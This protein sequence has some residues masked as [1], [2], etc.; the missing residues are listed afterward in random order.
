MRILVWDDFPITNSGGPSGYVYNVYEYLKHNPSENIFFLS[1]LRKTNSHQTN[2]FKTDNYDKTRIQK[3]YS[4]L[5]N[6]QNRL[7]KYSLIIYHFIK[8]AI[9]SNTS[10]IKYNIYKIRNFTDKQFNDKYEI[11]VDISVLNEYD[12]I[13]FHFTTQLTRF[14]ATY[15]NY[16]SKIILTTHCP[17]SC[18]DEQLYCEKKWMR[19]FRQF[20][21]N[22]ECKAFYKSDFIMFP[23]A[24]AM[25]PYR[26]VKK[27]KK[28]L[29]NRK[30]RIFFVPTSILD[31]KTSANE[32]DIRTKLGIPADNIVIT[33]FGRHNHIKGYDIIKKNGIKL[34][35]AHKDCTI[36]CAGTGEITAP[37]HERWLELGF[38][39]NIIDYY[40]ISDLH[41]IP[42]RDTYFDIALLEVLRAGKHVVVSRTGGN[43]YF[44]NLP[45]EKTSAIHFFNVNK[46]KDFLSTIEKVI[47]QKQN[48]KDS[49]ENGK[50]Q[51]RLLFLNHFNMNTYIQNYTNTIKSLE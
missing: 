48:E 17:C 51:N 41:I 14:L 16:K 29:D 46:R 3:L 35:N 27:I 49:F 1:D 23:C 11:G 34:L 6:S 20:A 26:K 22:N 45:Q 30:D 37:K 4:H 40:V 12:Y 5:N 42:N 25:E 24:E 39:N 33:F 43:K 31:T 2:E 47:E 9:T 36:V 18:V 21:I 38:V 8:K 7:I 28:A 13:H 32:S 10:K 19:L 15:S 44:Y 50:K